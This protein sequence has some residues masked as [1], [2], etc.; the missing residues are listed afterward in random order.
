MLHAHTKW[1]L[2]IYVLCFLIGQ[3]N[4]MN[5]YSFF[6]KE[7]TVKKSIDDRFNDDNLEGTDNFSEKKRES[8]SLWIDK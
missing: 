1:L 4:I 8:F 3:H 2:R 6:F 5:N 7:K